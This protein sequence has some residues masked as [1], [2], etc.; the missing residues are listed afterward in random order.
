MRSMLTSRELGR[1][2]FYGEGE[3]RN[4][5]KAF[6]LLLL[7]HSSRPNSLLE[8]RTAAL[9]TPTVD[10]RTTSKLL[11]CYYSCYYFRS[12]WPLPEPA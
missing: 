1:A 7:A 3:K 12:I 2:L 5:R 4:Y 10:E 8:S 6:P 11:P 9:M